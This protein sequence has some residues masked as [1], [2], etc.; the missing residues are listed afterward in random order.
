MNSHEFIHPE[1]EMAMRNLEGVPGF[2]TVARFILEHFTENLLHGLYMAQMVR[3]SPTQLPEIYNLLPPICGK[4]GIDLPELYLTMDPAPNAWTIGDKRK[5]IVLTSGLLDHI[6]N[7]KELQSIIAHECGHILCRHVFYNTVAILL[8][9]FGESLGFGQVVLAPILLAI[10]YW[11]RRSELSAD[12]AST[13]Y[14]GGPD[15]PCRALLRI[16]GGPDNLTKNINLQEYAE[17]AKAYDEL[18]A[19]S[20][21]NK[22]LQNM[23][24]MNADHPFAAVRI[25]E[26][27]SW[28]ASPQFDR[29]KD[30][31]ARAA[32]EPRCPKC[33]KRVTAKA[34]FC[35]YCGNNLKGVK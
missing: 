6:T 11:Q 7:K 18:L 28:T 24:V 9:N 12:R 27:L 17:Q 15:V 22:L 16:C 1:D 34:K 3:I 19:N 31:M 8:V 30:A 35:R 4:F 14:I 13:V 26:I 5:F 25:R 33:G 21:W 29:L 32:V 10:K 2:D 20:K 23:A